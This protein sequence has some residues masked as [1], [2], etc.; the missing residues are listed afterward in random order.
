M[1]LYVRYSLSCS[2][3]FCTLLYGSNHL[4]IGVEI[5]SCGNR[6]FSFSF[7]KVSTHLKKNVFDLVTRRWILYI[8]E[9]FVIDRVQL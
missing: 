9:N 1:A 5:A 7:D 8:T 6:T 4:D 2:S 3:D